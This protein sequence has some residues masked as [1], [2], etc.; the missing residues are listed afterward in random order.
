MTKMTPL[1]CVELQLAAYNER[2]LHRF[3]TA[4]SDTVRSYR[5]PDMA[6]L[7]DGKA[8]F[9]DFYARNRFVHEGLHAELINRMVVGNKVFDHERIHGLAPEPL[10]TA[11]IFMVED[12]L[13]ETVFFVPAISPS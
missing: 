9:A 7:L 1:E 2:N 8:A 6:L 12:G 5:L 3:L 4:F 13:I 11:V 10:E